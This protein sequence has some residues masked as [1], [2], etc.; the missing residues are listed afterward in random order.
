MG[1]GVETERVNIKS[2]SWYESEVEMGH[3]MSI[4][5]GYILHATSLN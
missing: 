2:N 5:D 4:F 3:V 1:K